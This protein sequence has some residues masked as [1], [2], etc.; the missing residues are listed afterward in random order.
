MKSPKKSSDVKSTLTAFSLSLAMILCF[1]LAVEC[2]AH[3]QAKIDA[4]AKRQYAERIK[5]QDGFETEQDGITLVKSE[6]N[7]KLMRQH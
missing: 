5:A 4:A 6:H 7:R 1:G 3:K 2:G